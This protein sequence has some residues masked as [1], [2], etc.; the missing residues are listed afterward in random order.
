MYLYRH[1][2]GSIGLLEV[3]VLYIHLEFML[4]ITTLISMSNLIE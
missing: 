1:M 3:I 2:F 4:T